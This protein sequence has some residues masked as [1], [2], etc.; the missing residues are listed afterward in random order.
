MK[1]GVLALLLLLSAAQGGELTVDQTRLESSPEGSVLH[2]S[3]SFDLSDPVRAALQNAIPVTFLWQLRVEDH[4]EFLPDQA[5]W[6]AEGQI[7]LSYRS[8]SRR[9]TV[10]DLNSGEERTFSRLRRALAH[11]QALTLPLPPL[12]SVIDAG[13]A[14]RLVYRFRLDIGALPPPL[15]LP[16]YL[17]DD[18]KL[19]SGWIVT[20]L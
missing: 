2:V 6:S 5:L 19:D 1:K 13:D 20:D 3:S 15:R 17:S 18:W 14:V 7:Q 10:V 12:G 8:L 16:A 11:L 9:Y 4:R